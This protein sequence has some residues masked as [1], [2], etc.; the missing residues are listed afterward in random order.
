MPKVLRL[1]PV[2]NAPEL[3][4]MKWVWTIM[5]ILTV[6]VTLIVSLAS[7]VLVVQLLPLTV[8]ILQVLLV[9]KLPLGQTSIGNVVKVDLLLVM[10][11]ILSG[12]GKLYKGGT[13]T[14]GLLLA[15]MQL[16]SKL[17]RP[18]KI[19]KPDL[20]CL[21]SIILVFLVH[22]ARLISIALSTYHVLFMVP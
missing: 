17:Q 16:K 20:P 10:Q 3:D 22:V 5:M 8:L 18:S 9:Q 15:K 21:R 4:F 14:D 12:K 19:A 2:L 11:I 7:D 6:M 13:R 1:V